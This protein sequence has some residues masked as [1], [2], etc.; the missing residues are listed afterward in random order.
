[1]FVY[2]YFDGAFSG[3]P[4]STYP[5]LILTANFGEMAHAQD[6]EVV[7]QLLELPAGTWRPLQQ[8]E[9]ESTLKG[10]TNSKLRRT[11]VIE[12]GPG[13][14]RFV[15]RV[16]KN[17]PWGSANGLM[18]HLTFDEGWR[19]NKYPVVIFRPGFDSMDLDARPGIGFLRPSVQES[20]LEYVLDSIALPRKMTEADE[21][22][23]PARFAFQTA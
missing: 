7:V 6:I 15:I 4:T 19:V 22:W 8:T 20:K 17:L 18:V 12:T 16:S 14:F 3:I 5:K 13:R 21:P 2:E 23:Y 10:P 9:N 11:T 1:M